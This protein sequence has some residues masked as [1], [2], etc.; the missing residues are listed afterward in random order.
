ME[1]RTG[2]DDIID[3]D[4]R[5]V[6]PITAVTGSSPSAFEVYDPFSP[7]DATGRPVWASR[8]MS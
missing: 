5:D 6:D 1:R 8:A 7:K 2:D 3:D 4:G